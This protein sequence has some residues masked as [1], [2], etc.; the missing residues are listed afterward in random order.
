MNE[1][2][3]TYIHNPLYLFL[4]LK[5][6][7]ILNLT[8]ICAVALDKSSAFF[9]FTSIVFSHLTHLE[10]LFYPERIKEGIGQPASPIK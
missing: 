8:L 2:I 4:F 9:I 3:N 10:S 7:T 5:L 6:E 1:C